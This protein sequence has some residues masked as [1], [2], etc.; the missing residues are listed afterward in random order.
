MYVWCVGVDVK[1]WVCSAVIILLIM[2]FFLFCRALIN[3]AAPQRGD[4]VKQVFFIK[5]KTWLRQ[6]RRI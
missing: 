6:Q 5:K 1:A 3:V 4:Q 2:N